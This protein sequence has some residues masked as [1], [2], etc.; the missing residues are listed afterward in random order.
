M[1]DELETAFGVLGIV[2]ANSGVAYAT[3]IATADEAAYD[4][5]NVNFKGVFFTVQ[6]VLPIMRRSS[7][8]TRNALRPVVQY[9]ETPLVADNAIGQTIDEDGQNVTP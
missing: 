5:L 3:P 9:F 1:A 2:L 4:E 8:P 7:A 6:A